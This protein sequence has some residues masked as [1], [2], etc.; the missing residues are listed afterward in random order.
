MHNM[1]Y[2]NYFCFAFYTVVIYSVVNTVTVDS[3]RVDEAK[4]VLYLCNSSLLSTDV[5]LSRITEIYSSLC[6]IPK[7]ARERKT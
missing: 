2:N 5:R 4:I 3:C 1:Y 6:P 7:D